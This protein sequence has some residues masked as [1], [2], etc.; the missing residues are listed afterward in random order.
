MRFDILTLFPELFDSYL[1]Q[2]L[3][4]RAIQN[5]LV[6]IQRWNFRDWATDKHASV[7]DRPYGGG[8]GMLI[9][10]DTVYQC[11]EHVQQV[12]P[13]PGKLIML[14]PQGK[15]LNQK[16]AQ[17]LSQERQLTL[18]CGRYEGFDE[19]IRIGL[20]PMEISAGDFITNGGEVP[21]ML[22]IETVIR[23]IPGVLGDE[24]SA[25]Y[26]SFSESGLLEYPQYTRPQNFR[27]MEVPEVLLSGNHQEIARW[28][29]EQSLQ[30]TRER[31][32]DLLTESESNST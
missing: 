31:R 18:L 11:V 22:I 23:L 14:T 16:L 8:P 30:R 15:T 1:E 21:A 3:L 10:C 19:R 6:E 24:S 12:V 26:D 4:K 7:D 9:G 17:E 20:E 32:N 13:E 25:K 2:G 5:Q 27:G 29:H 28:R